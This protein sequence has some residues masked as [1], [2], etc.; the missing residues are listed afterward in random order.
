MSFGAMAAWQAWLLLL[1]AGAAAAWLFTIKVRPPRVHV[2]SLLLW[3]RVL[4]Q[5]REL[6]I[7]ERIR[8]AVSLA[9]TVLLALALAMAVTRPGPARSGDSRG[10]VVIVLDSSR[11]PTGWSKGRPLTWR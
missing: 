7:W 1:G 10:R 4:D 9:A 6:T 8:R 3:R 2:P 11:R 5:S